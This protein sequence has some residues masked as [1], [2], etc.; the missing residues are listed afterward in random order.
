MLGRAE[1]FQ[2]EGFVVSPEAVLS[3]EAVD[4]CRAHLARVLDGVYDRNVPPTKAPKKLDLSKLDKNDKRRRATLQVINI[5]HCDSVFQRVVHS[6]E[7]GKLV[8]TLAGWPQGARVAQDQIWMKPPGAAALTFHR[9]TPYFPFVPG[10]IVTLW[11]TFDD[12]SGPDAAEKGPLEYY[13]GSHRWEDGR[14]GIATY[15][16]DKD[17]TAHLRS[18]AERTDGVEYDP[19]RIV[20]VVTPAGGISVHDGRTWHGS[21]VNKSALPRRGIGIHFAPADIVFR[22]GWIPPQWE[23]VR[24]KYNA[25]LN[26][27]ARPE[28]ASTAVAAEAETKRHMPENTPAPRSEGDAATSEGDAAPPADSEAA[29]PDPTVPESECPITYRPGS[30]ASD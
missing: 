21:G 3:P 16:F 12:L 6:P 30:A 11:V 17:H 29:V 14:N 13:P 20:R 19:A 18:A 22:P 5:R 4:A 25:Q 24:A 27:G 10:Q 7:L 8:A 23:A 28:A 15:F 26:E 9:D 1:E 2:R